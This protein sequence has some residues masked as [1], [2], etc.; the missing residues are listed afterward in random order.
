MS[1]DS[2]VN[3]VLVGYVAGRVTAAQLVASVTAVY[4]RERR[5]G[6]RE[7]LRPIMEVIERHP[8]VVELSSIAERPGFGLR[9][10]ERPLPKRYEPELKAAVQQVVNTLPVTRSPFPEDR[11]RK[12]GLLGRIVAALRR[13]FS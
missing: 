3:D 9:L 2:S 7:T 11:P 13:V 1:S 4:Y 6:K 8:G 5:N 10:A 12:M